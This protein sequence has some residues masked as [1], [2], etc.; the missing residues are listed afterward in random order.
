MAWHSHCARGREETF[1][2]TISPYDAGVSALVVVVLFLLCLLFPYTGDDW[3]WGSSFGLEQLRNGFANYNG[4]YVGNLMALALTRCRFLRALVM[5]ITLYA[6]CWCIDR[7]VGRN[8]SSSFWISLALLLAMPSNIRSQGVAWTSG[9]VNYAIPSLLILLYLYSFRDVLVLSKR[10]VK[11]QFSGMLF[12][13]GLVNSLI[14]ENV[15]VYNV[16]VSLGMVIY[17]RTKHGFYDKR[18]LSFLFGSCIGC[19]IMFSNSA[20]IAAATGQSNYQKLNKGPLIK[21]MISKFCLTINPD[22]C[23]RNTAINVIFAI[24]SFSYAQEKRS[25]KSLLTCVV[26]SLVAG[27]SL[28]CAAGGFSQGQSDVLTKK[29]IVY[30]A[31][32]ITMLVLVFIMHCEDG[33]SVAAP[34]A[35]VSM[36]IIVAPLLIVNPVGPRHFLITYCLFVLLTCLYLDKCF[37]DSQTRCHAIRLIQYT[38]CLLCISWYL[39]YGVIALGELRRV[40]YIDNALKTNASIIHIKPLPYSSYIESPNPTTANPPEYFTKCFRA[41]YGID[42]TI[43]IEKE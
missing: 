30:A 13:L 43:D 26:C 16:I 1:P 38:S 28:L 17:T 22:F 39:L 32:T 42:H 18:Q 2:W 10:P 15:S 3:F 12:L 31:L 20:Y 41:Y 36:G 19:A 14:M 4:R 34:L 11:K 8:D 21:S 5:S 37:S 23:I 25:R 27:I 35:I 7:I 29:D 6:I 24:C 40:S 9:F 33:G